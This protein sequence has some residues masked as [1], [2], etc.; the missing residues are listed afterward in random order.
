MGGIVTHECS[1]EIK[2]LRSMT[3]ALNDIV[4]AVRVQSTSVPHEQH[5]PEAAL[6]SSRKVC[7]G[8]CHPKTCSADNGR[9]TMIIRIPLEKCVGSIASS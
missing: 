6:R 2:I 4:C 1:L 9:D 8:T 5:V 7:Q 3:S